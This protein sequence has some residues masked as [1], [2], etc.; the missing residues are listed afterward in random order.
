MEI[1]NALVGSI[2]PQEMMAILRW[3]VPYM[4][5]PERT[6]LLADMRAHAPAPVFSAALD[7]VQPHL[8]PFEWIKLMASLGLPAAAPTRETACA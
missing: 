8:T 4:S 6:A 5:P 1:H 3:L 7:A 2:A